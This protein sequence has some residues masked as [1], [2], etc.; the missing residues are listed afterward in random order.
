[1]AILYSSVYRRTNT[2]QDALGLHVV[3]QTTFFTGVKVP[4]RS[5]YLTH[6]TSRGLDT[7]SKTCLRFA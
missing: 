2:F 6:S 4:L 1:M 3:Q 7:K 5:F